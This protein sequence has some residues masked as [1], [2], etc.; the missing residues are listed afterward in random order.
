MV[1][2]TVTVKSGRTKYPLSV[3]DSRHHHDA[4]ERRGPSRKSAVQKNC[5]GT[6]VTVIRQT[7]SMTCLQAVRELRDPLF[8]LMVKRYSADKAARRR[9]GG[10][11]AAIK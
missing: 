11:L 9:V 6:R 5:N 2:T 7:A 4:S 8:F 10:N 3:L 1:Q